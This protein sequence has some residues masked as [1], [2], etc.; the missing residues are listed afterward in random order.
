M[1][2]AATK[3]LA[4]KKGGARRN[5]AARATTDRPVLKLPLEGKIKRSDIRKAVR[6]VHKEKA[7][8]RVR[9]SS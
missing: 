1:K 4:A 5:G 7:E 3:P 9:A 2:K 6:A 8:A